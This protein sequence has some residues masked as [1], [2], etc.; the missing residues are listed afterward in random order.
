MGEL[1]GSPTLVKTR[2]ALEGKNSCYVERDPSW[3]I[4]SAVLA[5]TASPVLTSAGQQRV[6]F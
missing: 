6:W 4:P 5:P 3:E 1:S 2:A